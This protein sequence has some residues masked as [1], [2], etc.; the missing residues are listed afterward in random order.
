MP[1][2]VGSVAVGTAMAGALLLQGGQCLHYCEAPVALGLTGRRGRLGS[3]VRQACEAELQRLKGAVHGRSLK[4]WWLERLVRCAGKGLAVPQK[5]GLQAGSLGC[6][7][8]ASSWITHLKIAT[9][10]SGLRWI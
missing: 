5:L 6:P 1:K 2:L 9:L 4:G 7:T 3:F 10:R 8:P